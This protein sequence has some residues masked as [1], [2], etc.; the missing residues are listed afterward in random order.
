L[1]LKLDENPA[2]KTAFESLTPGRQRGYLLFFAAP[3]QSKTRVT[4]IENAMPQIF[5]GKGIHD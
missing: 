1:Q 2:F 3:K 4:R 5:N